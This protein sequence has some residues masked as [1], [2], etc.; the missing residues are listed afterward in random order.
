MMAST[1]RAAR[2]PGRFA[3]RAA[4]SPV[5]TDLTDGLSARFV[6]T[7]T[8]ASLARKPMGNHRKATLLLL[9]ASDVVRS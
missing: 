1:T 6:S 5:A 3:G 8:S 7:L 4:G 9:Y 2:P